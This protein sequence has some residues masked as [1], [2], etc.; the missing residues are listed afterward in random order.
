MGVAVQIQGGVPGVRNEKSGSF[1]LGTGRVRRA[2]RAMRRNEGGGLTHAV[3]LERKFG[4]TT[5]SDEAMSDEARKLTQY[6]LLRAK[7]QPQRP[8]KKTAEGELDRLVSAMEDR[9]RQDEKKETAKPKLDP[10]QK[11]R[12]QMV[13]EF[14]PVFV[15]LV[16]KYS[17]TGVAMHM[18]ASNLLEGGREINFEFGL[19]EYRTQLQGTVTSDSIAFH[20]MRFAPQIRGQ[21]VAGPM[22][23]L[24][25]LSAK[26]FREFVCSRLTVLIRQASRRS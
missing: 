24:K 22:L 25:G 3:R 1:E 6:E 2:A 15:E 18:D 21:I 19:G 7:N 14:V 20:E 10:L 12:E 5:M 9:R 16:E 26:T 8:I 13:R 4:V 11:L 17:E 23:R